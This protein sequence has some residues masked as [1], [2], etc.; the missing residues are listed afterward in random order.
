MATLGDA[1]RFL[2]SALARA[3]EAWSDDALL[4]SMFRDLGW[5]L[6]SVPPQIAAAGGALS[7]LESLWLEVEH[8]EL[9]LAQVEQIAT[10]VGQLWTALQALDAMPSPAGLADFTRDLAA[11]IVDYWLIEALRRDRWIAL[12]LLELLG[13]VEIRYVAEAAQRKRYIVRRIHWDL[14]PTLF[15]DPGVGFRERFGWGTDEFDAGAVLARLRDLLTELRWVTKLSEARDGELAA[16]GHT[17]SDRPLCLDLQLLS[18]ERAGAAVEAGVR[19]LPVRVGA[20]PPGLAFVPYVGTGLGKTFQLDDHVSVSIDAS[21]DVQGGVVASWLPERGVSVQLGGPTGTTA[22]SGHATLELDISDPD[23]PE[24]V[25]IDAL[26][27]RLVGRTAVGLARLDVGTTT[28]FAIEAGLKDGILRWD[29]S[30]APGVIAS[31]IGDRSFEVPATIGIGWSSAHGIYLR[32]GNALGVVIPAT[33]R[34]GPVVLTGFRIEIESIEHGAALRLGTDGK[35]TIGPVTIGWQGLGVRIAVARQT[36]GGALPVA[37]EI[38]GAAPTAIE[39]VIE[40]SLIS[41]GGTIQRTSDD[42]FAGALT[43]DAH[44]FHIS[45]AIAVEKVDGHYS[46]AV[47]ASATWPGIPLGMGFTLDGLTAIVGIRRRVDDEAGRTLV[48]SGG[49]GA[50]FSGTDPMR[51]LASLGALLPSAPDRY[52]VGLG[53]TIGWGS[54]PMIEAN[55][56]ILAEIPAPIRIVLLASAQVGLPNLAN[57]VVDLRIDAIGVLDL[58]RG[59]L[60]LDASLHDSQLAG[61]PLSGDL[62]LRLGWGDS[63]SFLFAMGGYHPNFHAP[64]GFPTLRRLQLTAGDNPQ[65]RLDAYLALT[66]NSAQLGAHADLNFRGGGFV[67]VAH[68]GFDVLLVFEP[69]H[70]EAEILASASITWHGHS[71]AAVK[72][73]FTLIGPGPWHAVGLASLEFLWWSVSVGFDVMWGDGAT[74]PLPPPPDIAALLRSALVDPTAWSGSLPAGERPFLVIK[75]GASTKLHP[76]ASVVVR[77]RVVPLDIDI[78]QFGNVPLPGPLHFSIDHVAVGTSSPDKVDVEDLF[79][80]GQFAQLS[81]SDRLAA[82]SFESFPSGIAFGHAS[83]TSGATARASG[84]VETAL[85]DP[86]A[87]A[88]RPPRMPLSAVFATALDAVRSAPS[89]TPPPRVRLR[90]V[91]FVVTSAVDLARHGEPTTFAAAKLARTRDT[92]VMPAALVE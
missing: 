18:G 38:D 59:T 86:L 35:V 71:L 49:I 70:F 21:F 83:I 79:A 73:H 63:P 13:V 47:M 31:V 53:P 41:G 12:P 5:Q 36:G 60:S 45:G 87:P 4:L 51:M 61:Y 43:L 16:A 81:S 76:I 52:V 67:I 39:I 20:T 80:P 44:S 1:V 22:A 69:F 72:L 7:A 24:K 85:V 17:D 34:L 82:P 50:L 10:S 37:F 29:S 30:E 32:G 58:G 3:A 23:K 68:A 66:S 6:D 54:P 28:S 77:Q 48:R 57:R 89:T 9:S 91:A 62:A 55:L 15:S 42:S 26:G 64:P 75:S 40:S 78:T 2:A 27:F 8:A 84:E 19:F 92:Q 46:I 14:L 33:L 65:L 56:A 74:V 25:L 88:P 11:T 90:D